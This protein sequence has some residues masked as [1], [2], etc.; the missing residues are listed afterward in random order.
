[1]I[2]ARMHAYTH[3]G[4]ILSKDLDGALEYL[5]VRPSDAAAARLAAKVWNT[6]HIPHPIAWLERLVWH[7]IAWFERLLWNAPAVCLNAEQ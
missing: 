6:H 1:M 5:D 2:C 4:K 7:P 3:S